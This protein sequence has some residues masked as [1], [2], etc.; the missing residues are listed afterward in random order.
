[1]DKVY[2]LFYSGG[3]VDLSKQNNFSTPKEF[4]RSL[5]QPQLSMNYTSRLNPNDEYSYYTNRKLEFLTNKL[6]EIEND[7]NYRQNEMIKV[8][9][10]KLNEKYKNNINK[11]NEVQQVILPP[12][13]IVQQ[14]PLNHS[15]S[16]I[17]MIP[18]ELESNNF[19]IRDKF[20]DYLNRLHS[21]VDYDNFNAMNKINSLE[22]DYRNVSQILENK[23]DQINQQYQ[24]NFD[25]L[26]K[27]LENKK[28][29]SSF[30]QTRSNNSKN[31]SNSKNIR[32]MIQ[33]EIRRNLEMKRE[34]ELE[35]LRIEREKELEQLRIEREKELQ[36]LR[37]EREKN[38][39]KNQIIDN[40]TQIIEKIFPVVL[41]ENE[42][43]DYLQGYK[44]NR[45][46]PHFSKTNDIKSNKR[47]NI[48]YK[49]L[50]NKSNNT[51]GESRTMNKIRT[52]NNSESNGRRAKYLIRSMIEN[53]DDNN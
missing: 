38:D 14:I 6:I 47:K 1:M 15:Y 30:N 53:K 34:Q 17:N 7:K 48:K 27:A 37:I 4:S 39:Q 22:N 28:F 19:I 46:F 32:K 52:S 23:I 50:N 2:E 3:I 49:L 51:F 33:E 41:E 31:S 12:I 36:Q 10:D 13:P 18:Y 11:N 8:L 42:M 25:L 26:L 20:S 40:N 21:K 5:S 35:Q 24:L 44:T 16:F 29:N 9:I 45:K 43:K